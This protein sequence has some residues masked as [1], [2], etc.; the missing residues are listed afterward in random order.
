[1]SV[2]SRHWLEYDP[3]ALVVLLAGRAEL[4]DHLIGAGE[5]CP[6]DCAL[7]DPNLPERNAFYEWTITADD[8]GRRVAR[9]LRICVGNEVRKL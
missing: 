2:Q 8:T 4:L 3:V 9:A 1:M 5:Q 7:W 6:R